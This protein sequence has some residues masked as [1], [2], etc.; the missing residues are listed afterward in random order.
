MAASMRV[1][2][3]I[4]RASEACKASSRYRRGIGISIHLKRCS[5]EGIHSVLTSKLKENTVRPQA[6][7]AASK[8]DIG[9]GANILVHAHFAS[10]GMNALHPAALDRGNQ[11]RV[12]VERPVFA[13][14]PAQSERLA[15]CGQQKLDG[16]GIKADAMVERL[17]LVP[18]VDA[19]N[20]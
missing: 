7:V 1:M 3:H 9:A 13:D 2:P 10:E 17:H 20:D 5:N 4:R 12:R 11:R 14:F 6:A 19:A 15:I 8:E 18:F 16:R